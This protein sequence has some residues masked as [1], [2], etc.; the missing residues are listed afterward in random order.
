MIK[1][2]EALQQ[3]AKCEIQ[4]T[5]KCML[6]EKICLFV[7]GICDLLLINTQLFDLTY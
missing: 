6:N 3:D 4:Y 7:S 5:K 2:P 1:G